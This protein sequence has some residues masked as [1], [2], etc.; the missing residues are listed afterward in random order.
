MLF[1]VLVSFLDCY[2]Q[3]LV[4]YLIVIHRPW[5]ILRLLFTVLGSFLDCYLPSLVHFLIVIYRPWFNPWL[6]FTVLGSFLD[7]YLPSL[8][9]SLIVIYCTWFIPWLLLFVK[10]RLS[11][12]MHGNEVVGREILVELAKLLVHGYSLDTRI[13]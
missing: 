1:T 12:N 11:A 9:H 10:V 4:H 3:S 13:R 5:F 6:L 2:L 7:C 8:V